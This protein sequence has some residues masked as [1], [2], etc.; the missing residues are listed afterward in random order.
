MKI[1]FVL[2]MLY[3]IGYAVRTTWNISTEERERFNKILKNNSGT[4][5]SL[6]QCLAAIAVSAGVCMLTTILFGIGG[7]MLLAAG[8]VAFKF[9][10]QYKPET[11]A[12]LKYEATGILPAILNTLSVIKSKVRTFFNKIYP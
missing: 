7:P 9:L 6:T 12:Y 4:M 8:I 2:S 5:L 3:I 1:L 10:K 11:C